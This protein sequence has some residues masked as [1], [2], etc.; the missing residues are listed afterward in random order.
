MKKKIFAL[1]VACAF[2]LNL[3]GIAFADV[4]TK[5]T[6]RQMQQLAASLPA[7][8]GV[9]TINTQRLFN[10]ALP[11]ILSANQPMLNG[12]VAKIDEIKNRTGIDLRQFEQFAVGVSSK[13]TSAMEIDFEPVLL[14]R[15]TFNASALL[16]IAKIASKGKYREERIG[17]KIVYIFKPQEI[18]FKTVPQNNKS[19]AK[20]SV[21]ERAI[22]RMFANLTSELAV[23]TYDNSTLTIGSLARVRKT[24]Q[25]KM[26]VDAEVL[27]LV[28]RKPNALMSFGLRMPGGMS[29]LIDLG[30][31]ELGKNIDSIRQISGIL[32]VSEGNAIVSLIAKTI[33]PE[34]AQALKETLDGLQM[35][36]K[37][38]LGGEKGAD[39][40]VF[41]RMIENA[42]IINNGSEVMLDL[43]VPQSDIDILVGMK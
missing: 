33:K 9:I 17:D 43:Q 1:L 37:A 36:G 39:K 42:R 26:R 29:S 20:R 32:D 31:D 38:F 4:K 21:F 24:F 19:Q 27:G 40:K 15:G 7:S 34:Q 18:V 12:I 8:D 16:S 25:P 3:V 35:V 2:S 30:N 22:D 11:Q 10:E 23:S 13:K 14:A 5:K 6:E 41:A 28:N